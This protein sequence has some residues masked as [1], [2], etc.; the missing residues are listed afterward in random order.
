M[1]GASGRDIVTGE[2]TARTGGSGLRAPGACSATMARRSE[3]WSAS[4]FGPECVVENMT[5]G[6]W[7]AG[8]ANAAM[9]T[10]RRLR[11]RRAVPA[12]GPSLAPARWFS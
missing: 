4:N 2:V 9:T 8:T 7:L 3:Y 5:E 12:N 10:R 6:S 11:M 1:P